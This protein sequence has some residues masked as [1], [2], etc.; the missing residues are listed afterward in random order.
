M[1]LFTWW[2]SAWPSFSNKSGNIG[3]PDSS[4]KEDLQMC[5]CATKMLP[6]IAIHRVQTVP[7][8]TRGTAT[9]KAVSSNLIV[10]HSKLKSN[11]LLMRDGKQFQNQYQTGYPKDSS[12]CPTCWLSDAPPPKMHFSEI[13]FSN[14]PNK[15]KAILW[16]IQV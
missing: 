15:G 10:F 12:V 4:V 5:Y 1:T 6:N 13:Q 11:S 16:Q 9:E 14:L 8:M 3:D 7:S 2:L